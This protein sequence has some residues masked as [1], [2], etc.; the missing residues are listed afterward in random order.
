MLENPPSHD[1]TILRRQKAFLLHQAARAPDGRIS[2]SDANHAVRAVAKDLQI[3][4]T[5]A[6]RLCATLVRDGLFLEEKLGRS[7]TFAITEKGRQELERLKCYLPLQPAKG[8]VATE[9]TFPGAREAF[10]LNALARAPEQKINRADLDAAFGGKPKLSVKE[11]AR[12]HPDVL[13]FRDQQCLKL[14]PASTIA[15]LTGLVINKDVEVHQEGDSE[16][17][18]LTSAGS[19][20]LAT[21]RNKWPVLP[22]SGK[23][24]GA[25]NETIG[26]GREAFLLIKMLEA[27]DNIMDQVATQ[28]LSYPKPIKLNHATAWQV[29]AQLVESGYLQSSWNSNEGHYALTAKGQRYL[30]TLSFDSLGEVKIKGSALTELLQTARNHAAVAQEPVPSVHPQELRPAP[31]TDELEAAVMKIFGELLRERFTVIGMVPIHEIRREVRARFGPQA[32]SHAVMDE[33]LLHLRRTKKAKLVSIDDRSGATQE[34]LQDSVF[35]VGET[36]FYMEKAH[37]PS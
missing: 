26:R 36:F 28:S 21:L 31:T 9:D 10:V 4:A 7:S 1:E 35:A 6:D 19:D 2:K 24:S 34:Q 32:A 25:S 23:P 37:A 12:T 22:P 14:N 13:V 8:K 15:V 16:S 18:I 11:L 17:Y 29:F 20:R 5:K 33:L 30:T 27:Q 3:N